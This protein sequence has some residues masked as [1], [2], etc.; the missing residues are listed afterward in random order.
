MKNIARRFIGLADSF[1]L[2]KLSN[3]WM[4]KI[5]ADNCR[6]ARDS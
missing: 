3:L 1:N 4:N 2:R 5:H 6:E